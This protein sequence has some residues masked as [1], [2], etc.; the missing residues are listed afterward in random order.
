[1]KLVEIGRAHPLTRMG[2]ARTILGGDVGAFD[3]EAVDGRALGQG[4]TGGGEIPKALQHLTGRSRD[5]RGV[6]ASDSRGE[7]GAEGTSDVFVGRARMV[8]VHAGE[9]V[10]LEIDESRGEVEVRGFDGRRYGDDRFLKCEFDGQASQRVDAGTM[11]QW[12]VLYTSLAHRKRGKCMVQWDEI[13]VQNA[14]MLLALSGG[15]GY[16]RRVH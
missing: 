6:Q 2:A 16:K 3:V 5:H 14:G 11:Q 4:F 7:L 15:A 8:V 12:H 10:D 9:A 13:I 1:M